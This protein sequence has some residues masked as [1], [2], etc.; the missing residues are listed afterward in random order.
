M[1]EYRRILAVVDFNDH[2]TTV[3]QRAMKL[4]R[5]ERAELILL[6]LIEP[7]A[8]LDGSYPLPSRKATAQALEAAALRRLTF[9]ATQLRA[10]AVQLISRCGSPVQ[11]FSSC[12]S[13][14]RP[15]LVVAESDPGFFAGQHDLL[16]LGR[17]RRGGKLQRWLRTW[18]IPEGLLSRV[19]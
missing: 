5:L 8:A 1:H 11:N 18:L 12:I 3:V 14:W 15:D 19:G 4:A 13:E 2:A 7:D 17:A 10:D 9:L 16:T 6:H